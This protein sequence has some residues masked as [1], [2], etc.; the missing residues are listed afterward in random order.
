MDK[1][2]EPEYRKIEKNAI[3][4]V[5]TLRNLHYEKTDKI[6]NILYDVLEEVETNLGE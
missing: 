2:S 3:E 1:V 5:N 6:E 4:L